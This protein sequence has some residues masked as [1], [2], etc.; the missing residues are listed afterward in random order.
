M[1][2]TVE[3]RTS[4]LEQSI[5]HQLLSSQYFTDY[6]NQ[7]GIGLSLKVG[8]GTCHFGLRWIVVGFEKLSASSDKV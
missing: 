4:F 2:I 5:N 7:S 6:L 3:H 1:P 8:I